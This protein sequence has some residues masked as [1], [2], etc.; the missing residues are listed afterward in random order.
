MIQLLIITTSVSIIYQMLFELS[1][2][3]GINIPDCSIN[4]V[5]LLFSKIVFSSRVSPEITIILFSF[6]L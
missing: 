4:G 5:D 6:I 2:C 3:T 1:S